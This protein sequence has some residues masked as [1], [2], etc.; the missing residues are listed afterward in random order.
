[1][2]MNTTTRFLSRRFPLALLA[3]A[4]ILSAACEKKEEPLALADLT[5]GEFVFVERMILLER[6]KS[7]ALVDRTAGDAL[8]DSLAAAWG[9][10][11]VAEAKTRVPRDPVRSQ[12]VNDLFL[13]ILTAEADSLLLAPRPSRLADPLPDPLPPKPTDEDQSATE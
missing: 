10:S 7:V 6:A 3:S 1:M 5:G 8:L 9:D 2:T 12:A 13:R 11:A 4:V